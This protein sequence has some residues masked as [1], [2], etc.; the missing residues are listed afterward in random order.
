MKR[1]V[2]KI[3]FRG[4]NDA[5]RAMTRKLLK[6]FIRSGKIT[7][8]ERR[9]AI[10]RSQIEILVNKAKRNSLSDR[11]ILLSK[12]ADEKL[13]NIV[14]EQIAPVFKGKTGGYVRM[15]KLL[16]RQSDGAKLSRL[17]WSLPVVLEQKKPENRK[18]EVKQKPAPKSTT[19]KPKA[20][21]KRR[22]T[23]SRKK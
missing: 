3:K 8:T 10:I 17:E 23:S 15:V 13:V 7:T 21:S 12:L 19:K 16:Q 5:T 11:N 18:P 14:I 4:G 6:N 22:S 20:S 9:V 1:G 2:K